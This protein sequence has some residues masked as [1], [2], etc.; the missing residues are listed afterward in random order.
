MAT[1]N[2]AGNKKPRMTPYRLYELNDQEFEL[3]V[4]QICLHILGTG[5]IV[6]T[7][8][9]DGGRDGRFTGTAERYPSARSPLKGK[10]I[11]QA[12]HTTNP[13]ASCSDPEFKRIMKLERPRIKALVVARELDHYLLFTNRRITGIKDASLTKDLKKVRGIKTANILARNTIDLHLTGNHRIWTDLG[14]DRDEIPFR[15]NPQ[16]LV[17]VIQSFHD[18]MKENGSQF[19]SATN[20]AYVD[21][22]K[23][24]R[25]NKLTNDYY[26]YIQKD[27][28]P[29]FDNIKRF[30]EDSRNEAL[31]ATYHEAADDL[32][33]RIITF[34]NRFH[35]FD[36]VL[37]YLY[38]QIVN[39][40]ADLRGK[41]RLVR[42][43]LHYMYFDC[44]IGSHA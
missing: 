13:S 3:L 25:I 9:K 23:K 24:N 14:F 36:E 37:T 22:K 28:L 12:K 38:D 44:D 15:V 11:I 40:S 16:G 41:K 27:S 31:R 42:T 29:H 1:A 35:T 34:R 10:F 5:T 19:D 2:G 7:P 18:V 32:K 4:G 8:G 6:F 26:C 21:K 39:G 17:S 33:A 43:F 30:L 20:F